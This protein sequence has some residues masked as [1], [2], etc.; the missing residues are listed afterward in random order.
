VHALTFPCRRVRGQW[1]DARTQ[2]TVE[3]DLTHWKGWNEHTD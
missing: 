3:I 1:V 2:R